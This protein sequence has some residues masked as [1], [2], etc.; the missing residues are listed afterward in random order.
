MGSD[1]FH[2]VIEGEINAGSRYLS[3]PRTHYCEEGVEK[4]PSAY[5]SG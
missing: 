3:N 4:Q 1:S 2:S 5:L